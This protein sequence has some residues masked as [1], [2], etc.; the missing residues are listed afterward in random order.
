MYIYIYIYICAKAFLGSRLSLLQMRKLPE[1][2]IYYHALKK[3][4][5]E[6]ASDEQRHAAF[7]QYDTLRHTLRP[8]W[9]VHN[10]HA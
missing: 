2:S 6:L 8:G 5:S 3:Q 10:I 1:Q 7:V 4:A 9:K